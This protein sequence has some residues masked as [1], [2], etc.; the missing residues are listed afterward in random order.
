MTDTMQR[1]CQ[2][3]SIRRFLDQPIEP[4]VIETIIQ[5][6]QAASTSHHVQAYTIIQV[7][8]P[9]LRKQIADLAGPQPWV[10]QAPVFL[11]FCADLGR[12]ETACSMHGTL[13]ENGWTE[14]GIVA[15]VDT[16]LAAQNILV[17]AE[18]IGLGGVFIGGIRNDPATVCS[19]LNIPDNAYPVFGMCLGY[20]DQPPD[21]KPRLPLD[22]IFHQDSYPG[23][24]KN[25]RI[26]ERL[27]SYDQTMNTYYL[28]RDSN[29]KDQTWT[30]QMADFMGKAT[31]PH[32]KPFLEKKG[33]FLR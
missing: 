22:L 8:R 33:F 6:G 31:R 21:I 30:R 29:L 26:Q 18:S 17:A 20:P 14:L 19:L 25:S 2:H 3:R 24:E 7:N 13:P 32:M 15:T 16:A 28:N 11:V 23:P 27:T 9:D 1:L 12:L 5:A 4:G 10:E